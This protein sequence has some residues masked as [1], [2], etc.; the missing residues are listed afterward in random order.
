MLIGV[1]SEELA[2][3]C[4]AMMLGRIEEIEGRFVGTSFFA[5]VGPL[6][7]KSS[8][9]VVQESFSRRGNVSTHRWEGI[10]LPV[11]PLSA[12]LGYLRVWLM[13]GVFAAPFILMWGEPVELD[14]PEYLVSVALFVLWL[15]VLLIPGRLSK[16]ARAQ[17][18]LLGEVTGV[19]L[20]PKRFDRFQRETRRDDLESRM[21]VKS[22][23]TTPE[24]LSRIAVGLDRDRSS[25]AYAFARYAGVEDPAYRPVAEALWERLDRR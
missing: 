4:T 6:L 14:R 15:I 9:Y 3:V 17:L 16:T 13:I 5:F 25:L 18:T 21:K 7:P 22:L 20:D 10:D 23:D 12:I 11:Q 1:D 8:M 24:A 2:V 19:Y